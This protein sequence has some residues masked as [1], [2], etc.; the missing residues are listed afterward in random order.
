VLVIPPP[1]LEQLEKKN[2]SQE[3]YYEIYK[4]IIEK[5]QKKHRFGKQLTADPSELNQLTGRGY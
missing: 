4:N 2:V 1:D 5:Y 3:E